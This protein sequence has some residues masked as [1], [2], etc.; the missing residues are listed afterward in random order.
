[1]YLHRAISSL[2]EWKFSDRYCTKQRT[3]VWEFFVWYEP[4]LKLLA[5]SKI[6]IARVPVPQSGQGLLSLLARTKHMR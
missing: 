1:M 2:I 5:S 6:L 4:R 3:P